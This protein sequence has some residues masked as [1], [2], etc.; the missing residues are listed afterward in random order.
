MIRKFFRFIQDGRRITD[1]PKL[2]QSLQNGKLRFLNALL[3]DGTQDLIPE[4][5]A[6]SIINI[7]LLIFH[8]AKQ[9]GFRFF[10]KIFCNLLFCAAKNKWI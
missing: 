10:R 9:D 1:L 4:I 8:F 7:T 5:I 2:H 6:V 3:F